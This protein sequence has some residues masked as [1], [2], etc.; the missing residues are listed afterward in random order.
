[1]ILFLGFFLFGFL[2][3]SGLLRS[4]GLSMHTDEAQRA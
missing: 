2:M 4:R 1:M 3:Y